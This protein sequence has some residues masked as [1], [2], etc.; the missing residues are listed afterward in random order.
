MNDFF[1]SKLI[2]TKGLGLSLDKQYIYD[3]NDSMIKQINPTEYTEILIQSYKHDGSLHRTWSKGLVV[4]VDDEKIVAITNKASVIEADGRRWVTREPA[5]YF[6]YTHKWYN[7][8]AMI[9]KDGLYFYCNLASP[10]IY[11]EEA[12]KNIDYDLDI[13]VFPDYHYTILDKEEYR[14]HQKNM[15]YPLIIKE[16]LEDT[17][18]KLQEMI[19]QHA[20][21]FDKE[22]VYQYYQRY[23]DWLNKGI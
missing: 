9:R 22:V 16:I 21:P 4:H 17:V 12:L 13:K 15:Q 2:V 14:R 18:N 8:I 1:V 20:N 7:V 11:D 6:L 5:V 3:Y 10:S 19:K 23:L